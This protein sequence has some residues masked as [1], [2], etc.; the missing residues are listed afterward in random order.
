MRPIAWADKAELL[1]LQFCNGM[2]LFL[3]SPQIWAPET[4]AEAPDNMIPLY[5]LP[6]VTPETIEKIAESIAW[7]LDGCGIE[8]LP[9]LEQSY[10][11]GLA[12]RIVNLLVPGYN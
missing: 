7:Y 3:E 12:Q 10:R 8:H 11:I 5:A 9:Q 2:S 4:D 6:A 1:E